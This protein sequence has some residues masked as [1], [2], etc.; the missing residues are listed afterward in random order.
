[1]YIKLNF[2]QQ[3]TPN[4]W[5][6]SLY[7][8]LA[9]SSNWLNS[10]TGVQNATLFQSF[11]GNQSTSA[12]TALKTA[13]ASYLD[14]TTSEI[15]NQTYSVGSLPTINY[16]QGGI[17]PSPTLATI[18][19]KFVV[20][21][22]VTISG[23]ASGTGSNGSTTLNVTSPTGTI[24]A[25]QFVTGSSIAAG[26]Y[27][28]AYNSGTGVVT[29]S[30]GLQATVSSPA[31]YTFSFSSTAW[32]QLTPNTFIHADGYSTNTATGAI[33][34]LYL[35]NNSLSATASNP[36]I[37]N[38]G[39]YTAPHSWNPA[40]TTPAYTYFAYISPFS[41]VWATQRNAYSKSG[42]YSVYGAWDNTRQSGPYQSSQYTR[43]DAWNSD[44]NGIIPL[45]WINGF[46]SVSTYRNNSIPSAYYGLSYGDVSW[47]TVSGN[48]PYNPAIQITPAG[49]PGASPA[50]V[51]NNATFSV[52]NSVVA[53]PNTI[54]AWFNT[55]T[56]TATATLT[57]QSTAFSANGTGSLIVN[58]TAGQIVPGMII[59]SNSYTLT[60]L[61]VTAV[62]GSGIGNAVTVSCFSI[63]ANSSVML[64]N[65]VLTFSST[66][67]YNS[68]YPGGY[69]SA[70]N[71]Y[72][73]MITAGV[74]VSFGTHIRSYQDQTPLVANALQLPLL[75]AANV[76]YDLY[77]SANTTVPQAQNTLVSGRTTVTENGIVR[78]SF[79]GAQGPSLYDVATQTATY[80]RWPNSASPPVGSYVLQPLVWNRPDYN[81][82]GG[83]ITDK[84]G[85]YLFNGDFLPGD[86]FTVSGTTY[87]IWPLADGYQQRIGFAV[88]K[89]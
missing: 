61:F 12:S 67:P 50:V 26:T 62:T 35:P 19:L 55:E 48:Y 83:L 70:L 51:P 88:P 81:N 57:T 39:K 4:I 72:S 43:L 10:N 65:T 66:G 54:N 58:V 52:F 40:N 87:S 69:G 74:Q 5:F 41:M 71:T 76:T 9:N 37:L 30:Q 73:S 20:Y 29:L 85:T 60:Q 1:M 8:I 34:T 22:A 16:W 56:Y 24:Q 28:V 32:L 27:V 31:T 68:A 45:S 75:G 36:Y 47:N 82:I 18:T 44:G 33:Q 79:Y 46:P 25:G 17:S 13:M 11:I 7:W 15:I 63:S 80:Y 42:W 77:N 6:E 3:Q 53:T 23:S 14:V 86:E 2:T 84:S 21:D 78:S 38:G 89:R 64:V 59:T 49:T